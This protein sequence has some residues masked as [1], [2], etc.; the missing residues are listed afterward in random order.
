MNIPL[1]KIAP[2]SLLSF[3]PSRLQAL[4]F[5]VEPSPAQPVN[6]GLSQTSRRVH[7]T[8]KLNVLLKER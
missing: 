2:V 5:D 3:C 7:S 1:N 6:K 4:G 8:R